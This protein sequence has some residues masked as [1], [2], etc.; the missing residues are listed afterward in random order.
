MQSKQPPRV[1]SPKRQ[2][3]IHSSKDQCYYWQ[4]GD[5]QFRF[6]LPVGFEMINF[7]NR[8]CELENMREVNPEFAYTFDGD[9]RFREY[10]E[11]YLRLF[12]DIDGPLA[13]NV[14]ERLI[15]WSKVVDCLI[16][17][18]K[19]SCSGSIADDVLSRKKV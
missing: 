14:D 6:D 10:A 1:I 13:K 19:R 8:L 15:Q 18:A 4:S 5:I 16:R 11:G 3:L 7:I 2:P 9:I 12:C 17:A